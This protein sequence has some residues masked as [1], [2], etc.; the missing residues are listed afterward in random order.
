MIAKRI[1]QYSQSDIQD[2]IIE[3][4][5]S[6]SKTEIEGDN[7]MM[8]TRRRNFQHNKRKCTKKPK[9][10]Y[11]GFYLD[12]DVVDVIDKLKQVTKVRQ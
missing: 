9:K 1:R 3:N 5:A 7:G 4:E 8:N 10:Q 11:K 12:K 6:N 2:D